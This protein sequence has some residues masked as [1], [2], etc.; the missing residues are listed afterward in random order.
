MSQAEL[1][2]SLS[3]LISQLNEGWRDELFKTF[4]RVFAASRLG[5]IVVS[6]P[7]G[8]AGEVISTKSQP[9]TLGSSAHGDGRSRI[10][11][12]ADPQLFRMQYGEKFNGE[13]SGVDI[14]KTA[15]ANPHCEGVLVNGASSTHS[16]AVDRAAIRWVLAV[17]SVSSSPAQKPW[18]RF[19]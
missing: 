14:L 10:L 16:V 6:A 2:S 5:V 17:G 9:F 13:M 7:D 19:W 3:A 15:L 12:F 11:A 18:W 8:E 4:L 1:T